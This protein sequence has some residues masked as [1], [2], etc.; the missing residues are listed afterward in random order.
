MVAV[1]LPLPFRVYGPAIEGSI[2]IFNEYRR[3]GNDSGVVPREDR[4]FA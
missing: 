3:P 2:R 1:L 4:G